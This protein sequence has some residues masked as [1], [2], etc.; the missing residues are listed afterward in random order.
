MCSGLRPGEKL[1]EE[2]FFRGENILATPH[3]KIHVM[4]PVLQD[5][6]QLCVQLRIHPDSELIKGFALLICF[7]LLT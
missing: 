5:Y 3:E 2:L 1:Y 7:L 4:S 6:E